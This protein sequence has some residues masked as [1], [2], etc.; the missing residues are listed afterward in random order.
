MPE[1]PDKVAPKAFTDQDEA[2]RKNGIYIKQKSDTNAS[3][4]PAWFF[5]ESLSGLK[6]TTFGKLPDDFKNVSGVDISK[7]KLSPEQ[8]QNID[9]VMRTHGVF[10]KYMI[11]ENKKADQDAVR[12]VSP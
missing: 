9:L 11:N 12:I 8:L 10:Q 5:D 1:L 7:M 3:L 6:P 4:D 2:R